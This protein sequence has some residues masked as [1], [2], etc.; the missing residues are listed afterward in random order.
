MGTMLEYAARPLE[1]YEDPYAERAGRSGMTALTR[2]VVSIGK[3]S[4]ETLH[5]LRDLNDAFSGTGLPSGDVFG[6][7]RD[8][9]AMRRAVTSAILISSLLPKEERQ[10]RLPQI[11]EE[12][13]ESFVSLLTRLINTGRRHFRGFD[14]YE[15]WRK[16]R[17]E[18]EHLG[19]YAVSAGSISPYPFNEDAFGIREYWKKGIY[20]TDMTGLYV[21]ADGMVNRASRARPDTVKS[22]AAHVLRNAFLESFPGP[23]LPDLPHR[24]NRDLFNANMRHA[25]FGLLTRHGTAFTAARIRWPGD[26]PDAT[27]ASVDFVQVGDTGATL[28]RYGQDPRDIP[29]RVE[30]LL[31]NGTFLG[32]RRNLSEE[33]IRTTSV[34][35]YPGDTLVLWTDGLANLPPDVMKTIIACGDVSAGEILDMLLWGSTF[36]TILWSRIPDESTAIVIRIPRT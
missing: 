14:R 6:D 26:D 31:K 28:A 25:R 32:I 9:D 4:Q 24:I 27:G 33:A 29:I 12:N 23:L 7:I 21:V 11:T 17:D 13:S 19:A 15:Q 16:T 30:H 22:L 8:F 1:P 3:E 34:T 36:N 2:H 35:L 20:R 18:S 5:L 10:L